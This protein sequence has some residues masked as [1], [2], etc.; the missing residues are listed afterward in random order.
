MTDK[1]ARPLFPPPPPGYEEDPRM[2]SWRVSRLEIWAEE[3]E[4]RLVSAERP[5]FILKLVAAHIPWARLIP[6]LS[7]ILLF[8]WA[9]ISKI[10]SHVL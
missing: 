7:A 3:S 6:A 4:T 5:Y 8:L 1:S 2:L 9:T 10:L